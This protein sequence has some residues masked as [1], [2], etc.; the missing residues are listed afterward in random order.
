MIQFWLKSKSVLM[1]LKF[2]GRVC[3]SSRVF[4]PD[5]TVL[6][7]FFNDISIPGNCSG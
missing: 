5:H 1:F 7:I 6:N 3:V 4:L 2:I